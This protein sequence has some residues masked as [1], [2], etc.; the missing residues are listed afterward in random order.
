MLRVTLDDTTDEEA[1]RRRVSKVMA[2]LGQYP[3]NL[4]VQLR[5]GRGGAAFSATPVDRG[6]T[7]V[8][9]PRLKALLGVLGD[10]ELIDEEAFA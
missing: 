8:L 6:Q 10:V 9:I 1:D 7:P 5:L 3:G 2:I 4:P